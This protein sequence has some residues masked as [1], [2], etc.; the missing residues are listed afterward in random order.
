M[1]KIAICDDEIRICK[2]YREK[3]QLF[4]GEKGIKADINVF[5]EPQ[6]FLENLQKQSYNIIL[7][8]IDMPQISGLEIAKEMKQLQQKSLL[9]FVTNQDALVFETFQYHPFSFIRKSL[10][11]EELYLVLCQAVEELAN[12]QSRYT[13]K[14]EK[15]TVTVLLADILYLEA[16]G[17]YIMLHTKQAAYR[18]RETMTHVE[19]ALAPKGFVRIH[20]GFLVNQE[21]VFRIGNDE[22]T[23]ENGAVLPIG[24]SNK[25]QTK[26]TLM[27]YLML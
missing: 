21:A 5:S 4:M 2:L 20:K 7:L 6:A 12:R 16:E 9:I 15:E 10:L 17:N 23:L 11:E 22:I 27:R 26:E 13:F 3:V 8:D 14:C 24:R 1:L 18:I 25:E 19:R